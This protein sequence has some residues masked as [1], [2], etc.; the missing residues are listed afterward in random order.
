[1]EMKNNCGK[2]SK[3]IL[4]KNNKN[5]LCV[6]THPTGWAAWPDGSIL[7]TP[8]RG[9][10]EGEGCCSQAVVPLGDG[11]ITT[12]CGWWVHQ[13]SG[14]WPVVSAVC[15]NWMVSRVWT[16]MQTPVDTHTY[17]QSHSHMHWHICT[18]VLACAHMQH[19]HI[20]KC[21]RILSRSDTQACTLICT[22]MYSHAHP[23][24][25]MRTQTHTQ[26]HTLSFFISLALS[27]TCSFC[28]SLM[29][30]DHFYLKHITSFPDSASVS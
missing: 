17:K 23:H 10:W 26:T 8:D 1:M 16:F 13:Q 3:I 15:T 19:S 9:W 21:A 6:F 28:P 18:R 14:E 27:C 11:H 24:T 7:S 20:Y 2:K 4:E 29:K 30:F 22:S 12:V 5:K 25:H